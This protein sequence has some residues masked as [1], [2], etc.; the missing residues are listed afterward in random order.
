MALK[1]ASMGPSP[2]ETRSAEDAVLH[3]EPDRARRRDGRSRVDDEPVQPVGPGSLGRER[4]ARG[5]RGRDRSPS[6]SCSASSLKL[7]YSSAIASGL[8]RQPE[9]GEPLLE[10][11]APRVLAEREA[12][13]RQA[14]R[15]GRH[16]LVG[17]P[18]REGPS[19]LAAATR[20]GEGVV[21]DDRLVGLGPNA[22]DRL[23][24]LRCAVDLRRRPRRSRRRG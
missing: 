17:R 22:G 24:E 14:D 21:A 11:A 5:P 10:G 19:C 18:A 7:P 1:L 20:C 4:R 16:H 23:D 12:A 2:T 8:G 6:S 3:R 15:L 13:R 9:G